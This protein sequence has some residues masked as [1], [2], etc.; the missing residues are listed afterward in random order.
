MEDANRMT[1]S[2]TNP[3][4]TAATR[5]KFLQVA[6][7]TTTALPLLGHSRLA[8]ASPEQ[9]VI[10]THT[11]FYDPRR[12]QGVPFPAPKDQLLYRPVLPAEWERLVQPLGVTGT[13][14][15]EASPWP[16]DNQWLLDLAAGQNNLP[17]MQGIVGVVGNLPVGTAEFVGLFERFAANPLFRGIRVNGSKLLAGLEET[18]YRGDLARLAERGLALDVN[19][20]PTFAAATAAAAAIPSLRIVV[21]HMGGG[22]I[23]GTGPAA[24]WVEQV[25]VAAARPNVFL[26][27]SALLE[28]AYFSQAQPADGSDRPPPP[29]DPDRYRPWVDRVWRAFGQR[30]LLFGSNWPVALRAGSYADVLNVIRPLVAERGSEAERWFFAEAAQAAYRWQRG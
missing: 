16:E 12:P 30:R 4:G 22:R 25:E 29:T 5:R 11:H 6:T 8:A 26:K 13:V 18:D 19:H 7:A 28:S 9:P 21:D 14:V 23:V 2:L 3:P 10:D 17:G 15:V 24:D 1:R 27:V 20:G